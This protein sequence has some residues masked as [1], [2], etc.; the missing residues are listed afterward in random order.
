MLTNKELGEY[1]KQ[2]RK[3]RDLS[4]RQVDYKSDVSFSH[5]SMIENGTRKPSPLTLKELAKIYNLDYIDLYE[6]AGYIDLA[7]AERFDNSTNKK[8]S[9]S[10]NSAVVFVYGSIPAGVPMECIEDIID[11]EEIPVDMLRG[12]KQ[13]FGLRVKGN[14]MEPDYL[15][16]DTLI[17]EKA[18]DCESGDDCVV[19][20]NGNDGTFKRVIKNENGIILQPLNSEYYPLVF[21]NEQ[22]GSLPVRVIGIVEESRRRKGRK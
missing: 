7:E 13:Y 15:D 2:I 20:V 22:I 14:S 17:L 19:M 8:K 1:L 18:D 4:L 21:S 16:G 12:G 5:L 10:S 6:K 3:S 11:T 9:N